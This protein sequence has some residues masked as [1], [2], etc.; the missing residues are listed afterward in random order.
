MRPPA[1]PTDVIAPEW[2][3]LIQTSA[4]GET[5]DQFQ[6]RNGAE[7][8][9][10][11]E[12]TLSSPPAEPEEVEEDNRRTLAYSGRANWCQAKARGFYKKAAGFVS[13]RLVDA[14]IKI[15]AADKQAAGYVAEFDEEY[16]DWQR[17][18]DSLH[19]R[20]WSGRAYLERHGNP[21]R[22]PA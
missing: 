14:G 4:H 1:M 19:E 22:S 6:A 16:E 15:T 21:R 2:L 8:R 9:A 17:L 13:W 11:V 5:F 7:K 3:R 10:I 12:F 20:L 18:S